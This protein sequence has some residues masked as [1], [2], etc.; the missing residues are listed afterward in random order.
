MLC[1]SVK[2]MSAVLGL[3]ILIENDFALC[4][5]NDLVTIRSGYANSAL[6]ITSQI[7]INHAI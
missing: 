4:K 6:F 2:F 7:S 1:Q 5:V 3:Q